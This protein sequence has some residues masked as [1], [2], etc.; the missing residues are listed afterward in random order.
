MQNFLKEI[1]VH[2][3]KLKDLYDQLKLILHDNGINGLTELQALILINIKDESSKGQLSTSDGF[4]GTNIS[5]NLNRLTD[6][7]YVIKEKPSYDKRK[8]EC[9]LSSEGLE[10][11][12]KIEKAFDQNND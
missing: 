1:N 3:K 6:L 7:G 4:Q 11:V 10:L 12:E 8:I 2:S 9:Y 5:H